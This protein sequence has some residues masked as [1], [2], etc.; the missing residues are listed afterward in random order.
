MSSSNGATVNQSNDRSWG[1]CRSG[2]G[3]RGNWSSF[4]IAAMVLSFVFFWPVGLL[5]LYWI[6]TGRQVQDLPGAIK[7]KWQELRGGAH[8]FSDQSSNSVFNDFQ[9][10]QY[11][12]INEIKHEIKT[13][14][15]RFKEFRADAQ[16][17][18]DQEEFN[19]FMASSP[20]S[21]DR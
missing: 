10:T 2:R 8:G 17:R 11:D 4:N 7:Q 1:P 5:V 9:Q 18:A 20:G 13:R 14:S 3:R 16:R 21:V 19:S 12:R 6:L 15:T